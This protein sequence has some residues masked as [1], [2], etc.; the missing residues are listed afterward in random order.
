MTE[1]KQKRGRQGEGGG[2]KEIALTDE[3]KAQVEALAAFLTVEQIADSFG[4]CKQTFY[5]ILER[6][7]EVDRRYKKGRTKLIA[8]LNETAIQKALSGDTTMLIFLQKTICGLK[9][10][11]VIQQQVKEVKTFTDMYNDA[12]TES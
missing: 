9:E 7:K 1:K 6:D 3:Q 2:R 11:Q 8:K 12:N 10:T 5:N 4:I